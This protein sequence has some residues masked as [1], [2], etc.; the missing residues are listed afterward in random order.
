MEKHS[1]NP[2]LGMRLLEAYDRV[3]LVGAKEREYLYYLFL[4]PEKYWKQLNFYYNANKA[5]IPARNVEKLRSL[6]EQQEVRNRFLGM[7]RAHD[8]TGN[9][10]CFIFPPEYTII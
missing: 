9:H 2:A 8:R 4:Y 7:I 5:W 1:W 6:E 10:F 3:F